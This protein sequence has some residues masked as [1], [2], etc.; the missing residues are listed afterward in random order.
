ML[1]GGYSGGDIYKTDGASLKKMYALNFETAYFVA[2]PVFRQMMKQP[3][4]GRIVLVGARPALKARDGK[5]SLAY[6]LSKS[7]VFKLA[8]YLNA[9]GAT[10]NVT[11]TVIVPSTIDTPSNRAS[12]P[13]ADFSSWVTPEAIANVMA[14]A[15][16]EK[17]GPLRETILKM[18]GYA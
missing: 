11:C 4:G 18:Y 9:E 8:E 17:A 16:S 10:R 12:M 14:F 7:L 13:Q 15:V 3:S 6:A 5:S 1:A 2:R